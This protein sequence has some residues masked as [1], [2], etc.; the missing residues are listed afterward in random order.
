MSNE[1]EV[2]LPTPHTKQKE[3][4]RSP[5]KRKVIRAGR[6]GGKTVGISIAAVEWFLQGDRVLYTAPTMEQVSRFWTTVIRALHEP[7]KVG[8]FR[9][10]EAEHYIELEGTEQRIKAKTAWNSDTL[11]GDYAKKLIFDEWQLMNEEAW[12]TV[13]APMLLDNNGDAIFIYTPPSLHSRSVSKADDPQHAAKLFRKAKELQNG[14]S[15][16][17]AAFHFTSK[18]NPYLSDEAL[19]EI[20]G[21]MSSLAYR[22]EILAEDIDE[23]PG[24]LWTRKIIED[25]RRIKAPDLSRI[26]VAVDP[27]TMSTGAEA[28]IIVCGRYGDEGY[29]LADRSLQGSPLV[30]A[31]EAVKAYQDSQADCIVA[32]K[33]QGGE[34]VELTIHQVDQSVPVKL[35]HASRGKQARAEPVSAKAE[36]GKIHHVGNFPA[37]EDELCLWIPGDDSPNR[38]DAMVWG[39]TELILP[40]VINSLYM[41]E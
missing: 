5:A 26:I 1:I 7:I 23:A 28:G 24:A 21:D 35:V 6:R 8:L 36:K 18:D 17:W 19:E 22:M 4:I 16:R 39:M 33:N 3:F 20:A 37:L 9:K 14:G 40:N 15:T 2:H 25:N 12:N 29:I 27:S 10:N 11:R 13:G 41:D 31:R 34:M 30:W 32:E 38:L